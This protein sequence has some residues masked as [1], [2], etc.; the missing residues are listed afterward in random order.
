MA[1]TYTINTINAINAIN[2][3]GPVTTLLTPYYDRTCNYTISTINT[4]W[5]VNIHKVAEL[6]SH[7]WLV[8]FKSLERKSFKYKRAWIR[9]AHSPHLGEWSVDRTSTKQHIYWQ[10]PT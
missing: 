3:M 7:V 10:G 5:P 9:E 4:V 8:K 2:T 1:C 6:Q